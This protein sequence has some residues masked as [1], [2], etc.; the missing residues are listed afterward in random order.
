MEPTM[1]SSGTSA[2]PIDLSPLDIETMLGAAD[3]LLTGSAVP[4]DVEGLDCLTLQ[5]RGHV[6]LLIIELEQCVRQ[7]DGR[8][9]PRALAGIG[10][11]R[12]RLAGGPSALGPMRHAQCLAR[13]VV[14][15]CAHL[16]RLGVS[17]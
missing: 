11:A 14:A 7:D 2:P 6:D 3:G 5:L 9:D 12:R 10:E 16:E 17:R 15:L 1:V 8:D 4:P 13:S